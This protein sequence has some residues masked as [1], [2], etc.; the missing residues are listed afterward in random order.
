MTS[1][2]L[3]PVPCTTCTARPYR[4]CNAIADT[5]LG[6]LAAAAPHQSIAA[7]AEFMAEGEPAAHVFNLTDGTARLFKLLPDGRRQVLGFA[8]AGHCL[9]LASSRSYTVSAEAVEPVHLR[10]LSRSRLDGLMG[11]FPLL[12]RRLLETAANEL[13]TAQDQMMLLGRKTARER[14]ASFLVGWAA[15]ERPCLPPLTHLH[16]PMPRGDI[17]DYLGL[18]VETVSRTLT[19]FR[20]EGLLAI[21]TPSEIEVLQPMT[22]AAIAGCGSSEADWSICD[23]GLAGP[24]QAARGAGA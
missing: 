13:A 2:A 12:E 8:R 17:A 22:L 10:R 11:Q 9:G 18:T 5:H 15:S 19:R 7:G 16:L 23:Q 20:I 24:L 21:P 4:A 14:V 1:P 3:G 6:R